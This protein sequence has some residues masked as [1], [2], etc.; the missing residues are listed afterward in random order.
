MQP[1]DRQ[2]R[3][4]VLGC[5]AQADAAAE[6]GTTT[7]DDQEYTVAKLKKIAS[8]E[9]V[10]LADDV[11]LLIASY[12]ELTPAQMEGALIRVIAYASMKGRRITFALASDVL[13]DAYGSSTQIH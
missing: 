12:I 8:D 5:F 2:K 11:A 10:S 3:E 9:G 13:K 6:K 1:L 4:P 7:M